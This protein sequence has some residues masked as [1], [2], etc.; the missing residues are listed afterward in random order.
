MKKLPRQPA[1]FETLELFKALS[2]EG[3]GFSL[4]DEQSGDAFVKKIQ[5]A[6]A[7]SMANPA[8]LHG[9]RTQSL[10]EYIAVSLGKCAFIKQ[11]DAGEMYMSNPKMRPP[12]FRVILNNG[13]QFF[14]E[15]KNFFQSDPL[16]KYQIKTTYLDELK[17]YSDLFGVEL[18]FAV[19]WTK[20]NLWTLTSLSCLKQNDHKSYT[21]D[22]TDALLKNEM[23]LLGDLR[24]GLARP[25]IF[26]VSTDASKPRALKPS[27]EVEFTVGNVEIFVG[28]TRIE[29]SKERS[30]V[31]FFM[32]FGEWLEDT[33]AK[34]DNEQLV[35]FDFVFEPV[36]VPEDQAFAMI[37]SLSG[38]IS[39]E[40]HYF[41]APEGET[42]RLTPA[43]E[44]SAFKIELP[45][46][47][48]PSEYSGKGL[49]PSRK[50]KQLEL[51]CFEQ[52]L[53]NENKK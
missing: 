24:I 26:R 30:L 33:R 18:K 19:Y 3:E 36:E 10:F 47:M 1:I 25:L 15:I 28:D 34:I 40:F 20:W 9:L 45:P 5:A 53:A 29:D 41:T 16:S 23:S 13:F 7:I 31:L 48:D 39:R 27:G 12:D 50:G 37:G 42:K 51:W 4:D 35:A 43:E 14:A 46:S 32:F 49:P 52:V 38:M 22:L 21:L 11:E 44:P 17:A 6:L 2:K 8:R